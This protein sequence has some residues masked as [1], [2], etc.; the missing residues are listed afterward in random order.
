MGTGEPW[1]VVVAFSLAFPVGT[2]VEYVLHRFLLHSHSRTFIS[3]RHRLHHKSNRA[4]TLWGDFRD[5][6]PGMLPFCWLGFLH[7]PAAGAAFLVGGVSYVLLLATVH[8]LSHERPRLV[9]WMSTNSHGLHHGETP[10]HNFG[11]VIRF[12]DV[13]FGTYSN[14]RPPNASPPEPPGEKSEFPLRPFEVVS[15]V[16]A[17]GLVVTQLVRFAVEP[18]FWWWPTP[19]A[20]ALGLLA[21]DF[22]SGVMHW[23]GDTWGTED[24]RW[25]GPRFI[26]PFRFHHAHPLDM[27][28][29]HFFTT[30]GDTALASLPF[31]LAP[32]ALPLDSSVGL[33]VAVFLWAV[34]GWGMWTHQFHKW[35][36]VKSPPR[37]VRWLQLCGLILR[38]SHHWRHHKRLTGWKPR[39]DADGV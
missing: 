16:V 21:A 13:V 1:V 7:S 4:D 19:V 33:A 5:F 31:L 25:I 23:V 11:I 10:R 32:F 29:S 28:K 14:E 9:F 2:L 36:H 18:D 30:N 24:S 26:R 20:I 34:G 8:K 3:R 12:W 22:V 6:L 38:P 35:A 17:V 27:L 15:V 39:Q 37:V